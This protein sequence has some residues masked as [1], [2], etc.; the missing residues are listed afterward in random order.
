M[1]TGS[2]KTYTAI[3][4]IYCLI[5]FAGARLLGRDVAAF[6]AREAIERVLK[7]LLPEADTNGPILL[8]SQT[9]Q[10][11][12]RAC[13]LIQAMCDELAAAL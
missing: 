3:S 6:L 11:L 4:F 5:K 7:T 12:G 2:G 13:E 10:E 9:G 1:A 8:A